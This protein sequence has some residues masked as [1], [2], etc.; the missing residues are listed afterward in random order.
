M[1][2]ALIVQ[3]DGY[4]HVVDFSRESLLD[5]LEVGEAEKDLRALVES[6]DTPRLI[7]SFAD[8]TRLSSM[9]LGVIVKVKMWVASKGGVLKL[10]AM[11]PHVAEIF[12]LTKLDVAFDIH[13]TAADARQSF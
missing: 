2:D 5:P 1:A 8:V 4:A 9:M 10:A 11:S 12:Q 6:L 7:L 3:H 13:P